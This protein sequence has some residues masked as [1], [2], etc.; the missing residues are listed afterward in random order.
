MAF[1]IY[2]STLHLSNLLCFFFF[3]GFLGHYTNKTFYII[4]F[5]LLLL[6]IFLLVSHAMTVD[7]L[8]ERQEN[9]TQQ[10]LESRIEAQNY[11]EAYAI[12]LEDAKAFSSM[13]DA[14]YRAEVVEPVNEINETQSEVSVDVVSLSE[15]DPWSF[16]AKEGFIQESCF[17]TTKLVQ[18]Q[19]LEIV[20]VAS[21]EDATLRLLVD[22]QDIARFDVVREEQIFKVQVDA[23]KGTHYVDLVY[24]GGAPV[25][26]SLVRVGDRS[27]DT[28]ISLLDFGSGFGVFDCEDTAQGSYLDEPGALRL[29]V[30]LA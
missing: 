1:K 6:F 19:P 24:D 3:L 22:A 9:L 4:F 10:L 26:I 27:I 18:G 20:V 28:A 7:H 8:K 13:F 21:S 23:P 12:V 17:A 29:R 15:N 11:K 30:E 2:E 16:Y 5:C 25:D 14:G